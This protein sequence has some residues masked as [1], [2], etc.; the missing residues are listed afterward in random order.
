MGDQNGNGTWPDSGIH[1]WADWDFMGS[2]PNWR[3]DSPYGKLF[4]NGC[5]GDVNCQGPKR[6]PSQTKDAGVYIA[7]YLSDVVDCTNPVF[8]LAALNLPTQISEALLI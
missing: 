4:K 5:G 1:D 7:V 8:D 3:T 2:A 6:K